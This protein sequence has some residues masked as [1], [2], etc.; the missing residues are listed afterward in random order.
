MEIEGVA[1]LANT[2]WFGS[3]HRYVS[4]G[5]GIVVYCQVMVPTNILPMVYFICLQK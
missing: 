5:F 3:D 2:H 4:Y 1:A